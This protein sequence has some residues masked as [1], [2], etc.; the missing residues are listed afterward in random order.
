MRIEGR[1]QDH[2]YCSVNLPCINATGTHVCGMPGN[3]ALEHLND[4]SYRVLAIQIH[5]RKWSKETVT[6]RVTTAIL[7]NDAEIRFALANRQFA[8]IGTDDS[9]AVIVPS[10][11]KRRAKK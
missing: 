9:L 7:L 11:S 5:Q 4:S 1:L 2:E 8:R 6:V 3:F 10:R